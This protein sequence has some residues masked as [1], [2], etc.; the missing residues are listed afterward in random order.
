MNCPFLNCN[1]VVLEDLS[2]D[3]SFHH[4]H[5]W[6]CDYSTI[7]GRARVSGVGWGWGWGGSGGWGG[8]GGMHAL[9]GGL[10]ATA[11]PRN[12]IVMLDPCYDFQLS[13]HPWPWPWIFRVKFWKSL[14]LW[15]GWSMDME[16]KGFE[17]IEC[18]T[19]V[20]T[21]NVHLFHDFDLRFSGSNFEKSRISGM[22]WPIDMEQKG[23]ESIEYWTH[24]VTSNF[25]LTL[26][27]EL[28][29]SR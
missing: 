3:N 21:F 26:D 8:G 14:I 18:C 23:C 4:A 16:R 1:V 29:F 25:D 19:H 2:I 27:L 20:V 9:R 5:Y 11:S 24:I 22:G 7:P 10:S 17:S 15:M 28:W 6:A 13:P 12:V